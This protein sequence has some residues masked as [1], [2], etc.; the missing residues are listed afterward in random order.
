MTYQG[1]PASR[2]NPVSTKQKLRLLYMAL[3][4]LRVPFPKNAAEASEL[5]DKLDPLKP[6]YANYG[7]N[8]ARRNRECYRE[9]S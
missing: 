3:E 9:S 5:M 1:Q 7:T 8:V 2:E 6:A 4:E